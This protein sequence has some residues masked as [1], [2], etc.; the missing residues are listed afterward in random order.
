MYIWFNENKCG[1]GKT[2]RDC[3]IDARKQNVFRGVICIEEV[4][5]RECEYDS[6]ILLPEIK[7]RNW[8]DMSQPQLHEEIIK[9]KLLGNSQNVG[10]V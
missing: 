10:E 4:I 1:M 8:L 7:C 6:T 5:K 9:G 2:A 3:I